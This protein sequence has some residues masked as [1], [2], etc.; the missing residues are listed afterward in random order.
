M[1]STLIPAH[2]SHFNVYADGNN[3]KSLSVT[4]FNFV[5]RTLKTYS[6]VFSA[7]AENSSKTSLQSI[8]DADTAIVYNIS[9]DSVSDKYNVDGL[10]GFGAVS[11]IGSYLH[12]YFDFSIFTIIDILRTTT[13][14]TNARIYKVSLSDVTTYQDTFLA[15]SRYEQPLDFSLSSIMGKIQDIKAASNEIKTNTTVAPYSTPS[16]G[17]VV[18]PVDLFY[19]GY[20]EYNYGP[21][22]LDSKNLLAYVDYYDF[23]DLTFDGLK[24]LLIKFNDSGFP[25]EFVLTVGAVSVVVPFAYDAY[26]STYTLSTCALQVKFDI[27]LPMVLGIYHDSRTLVIKESGVVFDDLFFGLYFNGMVEVS[28]MFRFYR[29]CLFNYVP[30]TA[31]LS[32]SSN[33]DFT[34]ISESLSNLQ[35][36]GASFSSALHSFAGWLSSANDGL[37]AVQYRIDKS[38]AFIDTIQGYMSD[39][40]RLERCIEPTHSIATTMCTGVNDYTSLYYS[41]LDDYQTHTSHYYESFNKLTSWIGGLAAVSDDPLYV[42]PDRGEGSRGVIDLLRTSRDYLYSIVEP[43]RRITSNRDYPYY[44]TNLPIRT[45]PFFRE[46]DHE[47]DFATIG[48][49]LAYIALSLLPENVDHIDGYPN[50]PISRPAVSAGSFTT[51]LSGIQ[52]KLNLLAEQ[53]NILNLGYSDTVDNLANM[54]PDLSLKLSEIMNVL[55]SLDFLALEN[56][57]LPDGLAPIDVTSLC[58]HY[59]KFSMGDVVSYGLYGLWD[60]TNVSFAL[61]SENLYEPIYDVRQNIGTTSS[62]KYRHNKVPQSV[63]TLYSKKGD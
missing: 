2:Y 46:T 33:S 12:L 40:L 48:E 29:S 23:F 30:S 20:L 13:T 59:S 9:Y 17:S 42:Q 5:S 10:L 31:P 61:V 27:L 11:V 35:K 24:R 18:L 52:Q 28:E 22:S 62:P 54:P 51:D 39:L 44:H 15:L 14:S 41:F 43:Y 1:S 19:T 57:I 32:T 16:V 56:F 63:L 8:T 25:F 26:G 50:A 34:V 53:L 38:S 4:F 3:L 47:Y 55:N 36:Q 58:G 6:L 7:K 37:Q 49:L 60:V 45:E 21:Y